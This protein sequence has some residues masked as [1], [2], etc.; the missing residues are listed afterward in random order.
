MLT[1]RGAPHLA[2]TSECPEAEAH[3]AIAGIA[4][5][6]SEARRWRLPVVSGTYTPGGT[7]AIRLENYFLADRDGSWVV[8]QVETT[9]IWN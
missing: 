7:G 5:F 1:V 6:E 9:L 4:T 8:D 3:M 2:D